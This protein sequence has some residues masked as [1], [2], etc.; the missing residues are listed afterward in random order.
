VPLKWAAAYSPDS[1]ERPIFN[2]HYEGWREWLFSADETFQNYWITPDGNSFFIARTGFG[3][4]QADHAIRALSIT[5]S[6]G[7]HSGLTIGGRSILMRMRSW[8]IKK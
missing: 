8:N 5:I 7:A 3:N 4:V 2:T 1:L 6:C